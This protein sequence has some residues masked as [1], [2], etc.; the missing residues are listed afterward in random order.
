MLLDCVVCF[1]I[2]N[3]F[4]ALY[5]S[6]ICSIDYFFFFHWIESYQRARL[7]CLLEADHRLPSSCEIISAPAGLLNRTCSRV[8][9]QSVRAGGTG[10]AVP[11][12]GEPP[13]ADHHTVP[14]HHPHLP[15]DHKWPARIQRLVAWT[16]NSKMCSKRNAWLI[17]YVHFSSGLNLV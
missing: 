12:L 17:L 11:M 16:A 13:P 7:L 5:S 4:S 9:L 14:D 15:G 6:L 2:F 8:M 3:F 10:G 1:V